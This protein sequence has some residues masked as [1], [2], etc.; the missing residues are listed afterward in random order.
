MLL[1]HEGDYGLGMDAMVSVCSL[2]TNEVM[3][4]YPPHPPPPHPRCKNLF[5]H[6]ASYRRSLHKHE[7][8]ERARTRKNSKTK[9]VSQTKQTSNK[10]PKSILH[11]FRACSAQTEYQQFTGTEVRI[12]PGQQIKDFAVS[13]VLDVLTVCSF[14]HFWHLMPTRVTG[15]DP[16]PPWTEVPGKSR[17]LAPWSQ[18]GF[19]LPRIGSCA[20]RNL[21]VC[22]VVL[23][24]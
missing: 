8:K 12:L 19:Y 10:V 24:D 2:S 3:V 6:T 13:H 16:A 1:E 21:K 5:N 11:P 14:G 7:W 4:L 20:A 15:L 22:Q 9:Q 18:G 17:K 23:R